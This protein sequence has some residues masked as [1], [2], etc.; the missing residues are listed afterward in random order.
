MKNIL[1]LFA[2]VAMVAALATSC[3]KSDPAT[4][5]T[6]PAPGDDITPGT[7]EIRFRCGGDFT[8]LAKMNIQFVGNG[9]TISLTEDDLVAKESSY[10]D[11]MT[12]IVYNFDHESVLTMNVA[13]LPASF[14]YGIAFAA[15][16]GVDTASKYDVCHAITFTYRDKNGKTISK[17]IPNKALSIGIKGDKLDQWFST[18]SNTYKSREYTVSTVGKVE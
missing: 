8:K 14:T 2:V 7:V 1:K 6:P 10:T 12:G 5:P 16:E 11:A 3:S 15:K 17:S 4:P 13:T 9:E 18:M